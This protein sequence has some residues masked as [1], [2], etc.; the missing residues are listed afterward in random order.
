MK[1]LILLLLALAP[2]FAARIPDEP[3]QP[4]RYRLILV[5]YPDETQEFHWCE[6]CRV[7][8]IGS[9]FK[10]VDV[11]NSNHVFWEA[12]RMPGETDRFE[13]EDGEF[14][15]A[16]SDNQFML[17]GEAYQIELVQECP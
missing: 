12:R 4:K 11:G 7:T 16:E 1:Q 10:I 17:L 3:I 5:L 9:S 2:T 15:L 6:S 8:R 13:N 14:I